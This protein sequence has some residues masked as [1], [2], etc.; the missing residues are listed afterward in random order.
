MHRLHP[1]AF[2]PRM[3]FG[4]YLEDLLAEAETVTPSLQKIADEAVDLVPLLNGSFRIEFSAA[5]PLIADQVVLAL[6]NF[7]PGDPSLKN[8]A[9]HQS[10]RYL[11]D[12]WSD[13]TRRKLSEPGDVLVLGS[14]LTA[15]ICS[16]VCRTP[17]RPGPFMCFHDAA[18]SRAHTFQS[19]LTHR[20]LILIICPLRFGCCVA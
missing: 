4:E 14:G 6:G 12:P 18:Y 5:P 19:K 16:R 9:F 10:D 1:N 2:V 15:W 17:N 13:E 20:L 11:V 3:L 8:R 7:P